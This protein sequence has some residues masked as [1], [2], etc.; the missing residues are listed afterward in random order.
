MSINKEKKLKQ[1]LRYPCITD[2]ITINEKNVVFFDNGMG[3]LIKYNVDDGKCDIL[4]KINAQCQPYIFR[5]INYGESLF[6]FDKTQTRIY[7]YKESELECYQFDVNITFSDFFLVENKVLMAPYSIDSNICWFDLIE[8]KVKYC[9]IPESEYGLDIIGKEIVYPFIVDNKLVLPILGKNI[10]GIY[11]FV[12]NKY[13][14]KFLGDFYRICSCGYEHISNSLL[15]TNIESTEICYFDFNSL[16]F[17]FKLEGTVCKSRYYSRL[18]NILNYTFCLPGKSSNVL[19]VLDNSTLEKWTIRIDDY[20]DEYQL[21]TNISKAIC[22]IIVDSDLVAILPHNMTK[23]L[24]LNLLD[25]RISTTEISVDCN[26]IWKGLE[27]NI[28]LEND[29]NYSLSNFLEYLVSN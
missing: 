7:E 2:A 15:V 4:C 27:N 12:D 25:K 8:K 19:I 21:K 26:M 16:E 23:I 17:K 13:E 14:G 22:A 1:S 28:S 11:D 24:F 29:S 20:L 6:L 18:L 3:L 9:P 5:I 10:I